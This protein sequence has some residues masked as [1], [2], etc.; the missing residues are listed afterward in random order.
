ME[1]VKKKLSEIHPYENNPRKNDSAVDAVCES[2][3]EYGWQQPIVVDKNGVIIVGHTRYEAAKKIGCTEV[4]V[5]VAAD[6]TEKQ[7]K[8]YRLADN[9][10]NDFSIWDNKKLLIELDDIGFDICT[11]F[12]LGDLFDETLDESETD[13]LDENKEGVSYEITF[14]S[15]DEEKIDRIKELWEALDVAE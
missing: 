14:K 10:T 6:L 11:G 1:I 12:E 5:V 8:A 2:I 9:R 13:A 15:A 4:P 7:V 3:R